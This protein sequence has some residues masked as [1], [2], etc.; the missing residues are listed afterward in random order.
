MHCF[1]VSMLVIQRN[2][3]CKIIT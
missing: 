2:I 1:T 3:L